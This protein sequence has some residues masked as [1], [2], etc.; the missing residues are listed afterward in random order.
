MNTL[1]V[2]I[3]ETELAARAVARCLET[4]LGDAVETVSMTYR[5]S[6]MSRELMLRTDLFVLDVFN[7]DRLGPRAEGVFVAERFAAA[8]YRSLLCTASAR[9]DQVACRLYWDVAAE[10][11]LPERVLR[12]LEQPP[13]DVADFAPLR[14]QFADWY[15]KPYDGGHH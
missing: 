15:R 1:I 8:G 10:D 13:P 7:R 11:N 5:H 3:M 9:A 14:Q 2:V 6:H 4:T 12:N